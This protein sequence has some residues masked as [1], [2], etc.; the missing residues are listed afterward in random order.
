[1]KWVIFG[2]SGF[3]GTN[4]AIAI[5]ERY[6]DRVV[7]VDRNISH[8]VW[9]PE[10]DYQ[11]QL[12]I[13]DIA[14]DDELGGLNLKDAVVV[15][16]AAES[17]LA[18]CAADPIGTFDTNVTGFRNV[19]EL[20]IRQGAARVLY[21]SSGAVLAGSRDPHPR[22][23]SRLAPVDVYGGQKA[24]SEM[25]ALAAR[26][27]IPTCSMRFSNV[28]GPHSAHKRSAIHAF[29]QDVLAGKPMSI[30]GDGAQE[31]DFVW[32]KD[33]A[34]GI[35]ALGTLPSAKLPTHAHLS[36]GMS[37]AIADVARLVH[38]LL[39]RGDIE[40][41]AAGNAGVPRACLSNLATRIRLNWRP[42]EDLLADPTGVAETVA[43]YK[44][45]EKTCGQ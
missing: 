5:K 14:N 26:A 45:R 9:L 25:L 4:L 43:W 23:V 31:R 32:V 24:A 28:Y 8:R 18:P 12:D 16:L 44:E 10:W 13:R 42:I 22:E 40:Y 20:A 19:L 2:G 27:R 37:T 36:S 17:G 34:R 15:H 39:E 11:V 29:V 21:A 30:V 35:V 38:D 6:L 7:N 41:G 1:V 3:I 33:V